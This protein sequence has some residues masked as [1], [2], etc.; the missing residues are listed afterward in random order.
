MIFITLAHVLLFMVGDWNHIL[1]RMD[2][3]PKR[4]LITFGG[5]LYLT[6]GIFLIVVSALF[7]DIIMKSYSSDSK[8]GPGLTQILLFWSKRVLVQV[9]KWVD[10]FLPENP[11]RFFVSQQKCLSTFFSRICCFTNFLRDFFCLQKIS[12]R[13]SSIFCLNNFFLRKFSST[14]FFLQKWPSRICFF[15][16]LFQVFCFFKKFL[17][18]FCFFKNFLQQF[19]SSKIFFQNFFSSKI[20]TKDFFLQKVS[21][22][23][24]FF[25]HFKIFFTRLLLRVDIVVPENPIF[26]KP[27][28]K[29]LSTLE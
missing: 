14:I 13:I 15:K 27:K 2:D 19:F 5:I 25:K 18:G 11:N 12:S 17:Q 6:S 28:K 23:C 21:S 1:H 8:Y 16:H 26:Y 24:F 22:R 29:C 3:G 10:I 20:S 4:K 9:D 7:T